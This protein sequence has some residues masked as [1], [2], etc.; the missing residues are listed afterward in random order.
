[1]AYPKLRQAYEKT[2]RG[3]NLIET[4]IKI[5]KF[6][7]VTKRVTVVKEHPADDKFIE[8]SLAAGADYIVSC[9]KHLLKMACYRKTKIVLVA[10]FLQAMAEADAYAKKH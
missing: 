2:L 7:R 1:L 10:E 6:I 5:G 8:C 4:V 9:D 3:E